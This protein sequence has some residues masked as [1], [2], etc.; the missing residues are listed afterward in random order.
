[1]G[2]RGVCSEGPHTVSFVVLTARN[3]AARPIALLLV[4]LLG[5]GPIPLGYRVGHAAEV[6]T[7]SIAVVGVHGNG[8]QQD[9][10]LKALHREMVV[11]LADTGRFE[12]ITGDVL[13]RRLE[14]KRQ[15]ILDETFFGPAR[16]A[17]EE[18]R[19][20]YNQARPGEALDALERASKVIS[21][22]AEFLNDQRLAVDI[23]LHRGLAFETKGD[24]KSAKAAFADVVRMAPDR[25]LD[26]LAYPPSTVDLFDAARTEVLAAG[27][28]S[29]GVQLDASST[30]E[31]PATIHIDGR[32]VGNA[33]TTLEQIPA[34]RHD[35]LVQREGGH[36]WFGRIDVEG[37][38][39]SNAK[40]TSH[41]L[42]V[43]G[44]AIQSERSGTTR[45]LYRALAEAAGTDLIV[46]AGF[47]EGGD[48]QVAVHC[49][50]ANTFSLSLTASLAAGPAA[51][52]AFVRQLVER[53][54]R[55]ADVDGLIIA[56]KVDVK[57]PPV[58]LGGNP[59]LN[60]YLYVIPRVE[61]PVAVA[62]TEAVTEKKGPPPGAIVAIVLGILG[63]AGAGAGIYL[64]TNPPTGPVGTVTV[65][66]P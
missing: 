50:S 35:L 31:G 28:G 54:A 13:R 47:D 26:T 30:G 65:N 14:P 45:R 37:S 10:A 42:A 9:E 25:V 1:M 20:L 66:L 58:L 27:G 41:G 52:G 29:H 34:G 53:I 19:V 3:P 40:I 6:P 32:S 44:E 24:N 17:F 57:V 11:G 7:A 49:R 15:D 2:S 4:T 56:E 21:G 8:E 38:S 5:L 60:E 39:A 62:T 64:A 59:T 16:Q 51:Q 61:V 23:A 33:P 43:N 55:Y 63:G 46:I 22:N 36:R 18:G 48:F 12:V